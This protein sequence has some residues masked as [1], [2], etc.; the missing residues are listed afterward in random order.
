MTL[1]TNMQT[2]DTMDFWFENQMT[3]KYKTE[4]KT[5]TNF[6]QKHVLPTFTNLKVK[7]IVY[8]RT[9]KLINPTIKNKVY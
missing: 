8:F 1:N 3:S 9:Q 7:L 2:I 4:E 6:V 5:I